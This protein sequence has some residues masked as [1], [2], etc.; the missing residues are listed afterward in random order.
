MLVYHASKENFQEDVL[1]GKIADIVKEKLLEHGINDQ[2]PAE[3]NAW[4][5]SL[6]FMRMAL[7]NQAIPSEAEVAIEYQ[8][9]LTSKRVDFMIAGADDS[10]RDNVVIIELKQWTSADK[11]SDA[12]P[13]TVRTFTGG[14]LREVA[15]PCYQA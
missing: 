14:A 1:G 3:F 2:N 7:E 8:I 13:H 15:H 6:M 12:S 10:G 5:N 4:T 9:P 11:V